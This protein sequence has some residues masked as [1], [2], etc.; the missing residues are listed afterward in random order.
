MGIVAVPS[1]VGVAP[2]A[3]KNGGDLFLSSVQQS[4]SLATLAHPLPLPRTEGLHLS[5][6]PF[7]LS[8]LT[9]LEQLLAAIDR[10]THSPTSDCLCR[11]V[12]PIDL[13]HS[14]CAG[15]FAPGSHA[16]SEPAHWHCRNPT[17]LQGRSASSVILC[18]FGPL[19]SASSVANPSNVPGAPSVRIP[20]FQ[21]AFLHHLNEGFIPHLQLKRRHY[22]ANQLH[23]RLPITL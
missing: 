7:P 8:A 2:S 19:R 14:I 13:D 17:G 18:A 9:P 12:H 1:S 21:T 11:R 16:L 6:L 15:A 5:H 20:S 4:S 23:T 22:G 3:G 10:R